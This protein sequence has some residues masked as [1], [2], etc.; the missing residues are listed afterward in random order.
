MVCRLELLL[1]VVSCGCA[2]KPGTVDK[3]HNPTA[4]IWEPYIAG[5]TIA[6]VS[7]SD[8]LGTQFFAIKD[9]LN[10][11]S[12][13]FRIPYMIAQLSD[14]R[15]TRESFTNTTGGPLYQQRVCDLAAMFITD[16]HR[17]NFD[18]T[19]IMD[20]PLFDDFW[21]PESSPVEERDKAIRKILEWW[22]GEGKERYRGR[23]ITVGNSVRGSSR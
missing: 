6:N 5:I 11:I 1:V 13:E 15:P 3:L 22:Q 23:T 10:R 9:N 20:D 19:T 12:P 21:F 7:N 17:A 18:S 8:A 14:K 2:T 16:Y 4:D